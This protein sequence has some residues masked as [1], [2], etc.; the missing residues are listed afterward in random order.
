[1]ESESLIEWGLEIPRDYNKE[2]EEIKMIRTFIKERPLKWDEL[3]QINTKTKEVKI[4]A[5]DKELGFPFSEYHTTVTEIGFE[6][7]KE[8]I[9]TIKL[10]KKEISTK[11][12]ISREIEGLFKLAEYRIKNNN[13][14]Y[15][16]L[17]NNIKYNDII[18]R[19]K[20]YGI[21]ESEAIRK[22]DY[23]KTWI[24]I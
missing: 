2:M 13:Y 7:V 22:I 17:N 20:E 10:R 11:K 5:V 23:Y 18:E 16:L 12:E 6:S 8:M 1:M 14:K 4:Y 24:L 3:I 21:T 19:L 9:D 15:L